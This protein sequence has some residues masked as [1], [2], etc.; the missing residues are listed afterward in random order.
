MTAN[1]AA[2]STTTTSKTK[3]R[4]TKAKL[5]EEDEEPEANTNKTRNRPKKVH[6]SKVRVSILLCFQSLAST[7]TRCQQVTQALVIDDE[8]D[9]DLQVAIELSK[10]DWVRACFVASRLVHLTRS[11]LPFVCAWAGTGATF[12]C[13]WQKQRQRRRRRRR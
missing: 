5:E 9:K 7:L 8:H 3:K 6:R 1:D 12:C 10:T 4:R 13:L 11:L 2:Y